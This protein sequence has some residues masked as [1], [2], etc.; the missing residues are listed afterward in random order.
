M[1]TLAILVALMFTLAGCLLFDYRAT[2]RTTMLWYD[3]IVDRDEVYAAH[4]IGDNLPTG[5]DDVYVADLFASEMIMSITASPA[6][7]GGDWSYVPIGELDRF[8]DS[9][10]I[11]TSA[12]AEVAYNLCKKWEVD[13]V[14]LSGRM[15]SRSYFGY[16][17][18]RIP[19]ESFDKF[20]SSTQHFSPV[21]SS[22]APVH[23]VKGVWILE[24]LG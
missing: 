10:R 7:I 8:M 1:A 18:H 20:F 12:S 4:W 22:T 21:Y 9:Q 5:K 16:D 19:K 2:F 3:P 17:W 13:Y 14:F 24:V 15:V 23:G 11:Y 6:V